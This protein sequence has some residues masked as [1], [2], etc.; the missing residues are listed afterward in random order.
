MSSNP[1]E[2][3]PV[4]R[5]HA[6]WMQNGWDEAADGIATVTALARVHQILT[7]RIDAV[8][9]PLDLNVARFEMLALLAFSETGA[10]PLAQASSHLQVHQTSVTN[11]VE[12]LGRVA[13]VERRPHPTDGRAN[14]IAI[15]PQGRDLAL[16]AARE[17]NR[18]VF[19]DLGLP[20]SGVLDLNRLLAALRTSAG[21][22]VAPRTGTQEVTS[23]E[24]VRGPTSG[25]AV[26]DAEPE[27]AAAATGTA[28]DGN[29]AGAKDGTAGGASTSGLPQRRRLPMRRPAD[30]D[31]R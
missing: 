21:D 25:Q 7:A 12:R 4:A 6:D 5:V 15:T 13:L 28:G 8:L 18:V 10:M 2:H 23:P 3:D 26:D 14:L 19:A 1:L 9:R 22:Y 30:S 20:P 11:T 16:Q 29:D 31:R 17:L 24:E 27:E